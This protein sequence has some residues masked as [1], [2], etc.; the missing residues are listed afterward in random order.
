MFWLCSIQARCK[1]RSGKRDILQ[2]TLRQIV[3]DAEDLF[4]LEELAEEPVQSDRA[5]VMSLPNGFSIECASSRI[6]SRDG[7][8]RKR[9]DMIQDAFI[10][11]RRLSRDGKACSNTVPA[12]VDILKE[13]SLGNGRMILPGQTGTLFV[14]DMIQKKCLTSSSLNWPGRMFSLHGSVRGIPRE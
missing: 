10:Q 8:A 12:V 9:G 4:L 2:G 1:F 14:R 6:S 7:Q 3:I 11:R 5:I 13:N